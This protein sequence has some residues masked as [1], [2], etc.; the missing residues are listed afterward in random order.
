MSD[1]RILSACGQCELMPG[2]EKPR[3][4]PKQ[5][6]IKGLMAY[7]TKER[8]RLVFNGVSGLTINKTEKTIE[9]AYTDPAH[10]RNGYG[11][12]LIVVARAMLGNIRHSDY[13][14]KDG[15][16]FAKKG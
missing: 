7:E 16:K 6:Q 9:H 1:S 4:I 11:Q 12:S 2:Y 5:Y 15:E 14:T 13:L 3:A 8:L 10:R